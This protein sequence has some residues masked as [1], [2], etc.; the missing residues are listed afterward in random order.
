VVTSV[1]WVETVL[2]GREAAMNARGVLLVVV[3]A[4]PLGLGEPD[5]PLPMGER[6]WLYGTAGPPVALARVRSSTQL[7]RNRVELDLLQQKWRLRGVPFT[8]VIFEQPGPG[9][10][11]WKLTDRERER[12]LADWGESPNPERL[13]E[14]RR[15]FQD[16]RSCQGEPRLPLP[17][18]PAL[19]GNLPPPP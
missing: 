15:C 17:Q 6:G 7:A 10:L 1:H 12:V 14:L 16:I 8:Y 13:A 19:L 9:P 11:S 5:R 3:S 2:A 18:G 4:S